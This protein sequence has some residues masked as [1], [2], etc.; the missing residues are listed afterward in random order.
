MRSAP[1]PTHAPAGCGE[2]V[3]A[4]SRTLSVRI[5]RTSPLAEDEDTAPSTYSVSVKKGYDT[6]PV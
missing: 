1:M 2:S 5:A 4:P 6:V 3:H